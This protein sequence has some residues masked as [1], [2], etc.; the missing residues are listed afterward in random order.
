M[1]DP[2]TPQPIDAL[3]ARTRFGELMNRVEKENVRFMVSRRG[4][5][6]AV[7]LSVEDY[8]KH[9]VGQP[10]LLTRIQKSAQAAGL[11]G[12]TEEEI[13]REIQAFRQSK[14]KET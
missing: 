8:L 9:I 5:P 1:D 14:D 13:D 11:D 10:E 4:K 12:M 2:S 3:A 6:S 7:I